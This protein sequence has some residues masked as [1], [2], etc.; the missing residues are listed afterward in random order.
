MVCKEAGNSTHAFFERRGA[1]GMP[2]LREFSPDSR[3]FR[4]LISVVQ[5]VHQWGYA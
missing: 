1:A 4:R 5:A 2:L 3:L